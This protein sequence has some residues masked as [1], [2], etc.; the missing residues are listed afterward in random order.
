MPG[1]R[2]PAF[3]GRNFYSA[4]LHPWKLLSA[5]ENNDHLTMLEDTLELDHVIFVGECGL[6]K[7][8]GTDFREQIRVFKAQAFMAEEYQK[9]LI[10]HCVKSWN[11]IFEIFKNNPPS[12]PWIFHGFNGSP[13]LIKQF[14]SD[15]I[16]FSFGEWL[17]KEHTKAVESLK[18]L[19]LERVFFETDEFEGSVERIYKKAAEILEVPVESLQKSTWENFNK[20][21]NVSFQTNS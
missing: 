4:G 12:V 5:A 16:W 19:P 20:I 7:M 3:M 6:D 14:S 9:P 15:N 8:T 18:I 2:I 1:D 17:L 11:E 10:I 21:E 13:E